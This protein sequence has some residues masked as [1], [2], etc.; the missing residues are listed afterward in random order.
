M[1]ESG[2]IYRLGQV[3]SNIKELFQKY[4]SLN[5]EQVEIA[6]KLSTVLTTLGELKAGIDGLKSRPGAWWEKLMNAVL[7]AAAGAFVAWLLLGGA[8]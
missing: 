1:D 4:N 5:V 7:T 6:V 3:E 8:P 2:I